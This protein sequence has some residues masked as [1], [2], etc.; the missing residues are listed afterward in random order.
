MEA[1]TRFNVFSKSV[2]NLVSAFSTAL[3]VFVYN[4]I[5]DNTTEHTPQGKKKQ[6]HLPTLA[7]R[8]ST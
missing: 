7:C 1:T 8:H 5:F 2:R 3:E 6:L 4:G